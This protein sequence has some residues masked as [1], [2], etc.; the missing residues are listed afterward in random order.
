[1]LYKSYSPK[2]IGV[3]K[4]RVRTIVQPGDT[5]D[6]TSSDVVQ[7]G[8]NMVYLTPA[9]V[10]R[11]VPVPAKTAADYAAEVAAEMATKPTW[12]PETVVE[13]VVVEEPVVAPIDVTVVVPAPETVVE[14]EPE[15]VIESEIVADPVDVDAV[16]VEEA[17]AEAVA[18]EEVVAPAP[19]KGRRQQ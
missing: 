12:T 10:E 11:V 9:N 8:M 16:A 17:P 1:M 6:L 3:S 15:I 19:K 7:T 18:T 13:V 4:D 5:I 14:P 2:P